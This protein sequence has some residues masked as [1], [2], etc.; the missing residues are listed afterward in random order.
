VAR[1]GEYEDRCNNRSEENQK[2]GYIVEGHEQKLRSSDSFVSSCDGEKR[3]TK[4]TDLDED[5]GRRKKNDVIGHV[6]QG[7][8]RGRARLVT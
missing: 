3:K 6:W 5:G 1:G 7:D 4:K 2:F 8:G